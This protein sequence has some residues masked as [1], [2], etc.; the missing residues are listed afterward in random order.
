VRNC[1][2]RESETYYKVCKGEECASIGSQDTYEIPGK[3]EENMAVV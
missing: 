3:R 1:K 2:I